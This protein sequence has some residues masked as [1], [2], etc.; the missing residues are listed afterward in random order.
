M[1][2]THQQLSAQLDEALEGASLQLV[3]HHLSKC[4]RCRDELAALTLQDRMLT[5]ALTPDSNV[6][7][8]ELI[9]LEVRC[10]LYP[11]KAKELEDRIDAITKK[12]DLKLR[13]AEEIVA[14]SAAAKPV[15]P[16]PAPAPPPAKSEAE[17]RAEAEAREQ[18]EAKALLA[19]AR[20]EAA[21]REKA[22]AEIAMKRVREEAAAIAKAE[23]DA[24]AKAEAEGRKAAAE[25]RARAEA[26]ARAKAEA[27]AR[28][29]ADAEAQPKVEA[30]AEARAK[31]E[32]EARTRAEA[33]ARK[34]AD[35]RVKAEA[36]AR[37]KAE[38]EQRR[39][40]QAEALRAE[41]SARAAALAKTQALA[42]VAAAEAARLR[43]SEESRMR[44]E[45][46][47]TVRAEVE[48]RLRAE[49]EARAESESRTREEAEKRA[50]A[51][52][53][54]S[55]LPLPPPRSPRVEVIESER[56]DRAATAPRR[57]PDRPAPTLWRRTRRVLQT[58]ATGVFAIL[59]AFN[60]WIAIENGALTRLGKHIAITASRGS[61]HVEAPSIEP[62]ASTPSPLIETPPVSGDA[63]EPTA[64]DSAA[65]SPPRIEARPAPKPRP[66][67]SNVSP[68]SRPE[69]PPSRAGTVIE[70]R[71]ATTTQVVRRPAPVELGLL[72][73]VVRDTDSHP[74]AGARVMM[75]DVGVVVVT[76]RR[77]RFCL[78]APKGDRTM[79]VIALGFEPS[80]QQIS[81]GRETNELSIT[82]HF[83]TLTPSDSS[84]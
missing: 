41:Q 9:A 17:Q 27:E 10:E 72:C 26:E 76:D 23:A 60:V 84:H 42:R 36:E 32:A 56:R 1:H 43:A 31:A 79:S 34:N 30:E 73:G 6:E 65:P 44:A 21:A 38:A 33:E 70:S 29:K 57:P 81:I 68:D 66:S 4:E 62:V 3:D 49:F 13:M 82:L 18:A 64:S 28:A 5:E 19:R 55:P 58:L 61:Q 71:H 45:I 63:V 8:A 80:R 53:P 16:A 7:N 25:A 15:G 40:T 54:P 47:A 48:T 2:L 12:R 83:A 78:T 74:I 50:A 52:P 51:V 69:T 77:G 35:D 67:R 75:A 22:E 20:E 11:Q 37:R 14:Q 59:V 24:R 39:K 46:E